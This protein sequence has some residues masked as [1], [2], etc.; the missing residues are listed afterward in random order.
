MVGLWWGVCLWGLLGSQ[1]LAQQVSV[2]QEAAKIQMAYPGDSQAGA[3]GGCGQSC[4]YLKANDVLALEASYLVELSQRLMRS[5][6]AVSKSGEGASEE[7]VEEGKGALEKNLGPYCRAQRIA[8]SRDWTGGPG[9]RCFSG[10]LKT[11][12]RSLEQI[13]HSMIKN[14]Q[15]VAMLADPEG[16]APPLPGAFG[17]A[18]PTTSERALADP[19]FLEKDAKHV[20][21]YPDFPF[22]PALEA[23]DP[24]VKRLAGIAKAALKQRQQQFGGQSRAVEDEALAQW[25][26]QF[27]RCPSR[28]EFARVELAE[29]YPSRPTGE[30]LP[31]I[32]VDAQ[33]RIE[34]D[35]EAFKKAIQECDRKK[36]SAFREFPLELV[37]EPVMA[38]ARA[39][40][41]V[42]AEAR[43]AFRSAHGAL[44]SAVRDQLKPSKNSVGSVDHVTLLGKGK[45]SPQEAGRLRDLAASQSSSKSGSSS[46]VKSLSERQT[47]AFFDDN[48]GRIKAAAQRLGS[49]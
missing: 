46:R 33:G 5:Y 38:D 10:Y 30:K 47:S 4:L 34:I 24:V 42:T 12:A 37:S 41:P 45:P 7:S 26:E 18:R 48:I 23:I 11:V 36:E 43:D 25:W 20:K 8:V 1:G 13:R 49:S 14:Y 9:K 40:L 21:L 39:V 3:S 17:P 44:M 16:G 31:R 2:S 28:D 35:E 32:M 27:P 6:E 22:L 15:M 29:R 19:R